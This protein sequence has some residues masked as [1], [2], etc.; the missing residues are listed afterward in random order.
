MDEKTEELRDIF[1]EV[2]E[3][4]SVTETQEELRGS[5][6]TD[7]TEIEERLLSIVGAM[8]ERYDLETPLTRSQLVDVVRS[9]YAG[10]SDDEIARELEES[11]TEPK[12][13]GESDIETAGGESLVE[14]VARARIELHLVSEKDRKRVIDLDAL[15]EIADAGSQKYVDAD[16]SEEETISTAEIAA[17]FDMSESTARRHRRLI[18]VK[19][20]RKLIG[21]RFRQKFE[22][23]LSDQALSDRLTDGIKEDGLED[24]TEGIE[25]DVSF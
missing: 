23:V 2:T 7:E 3:T 17:E 6:A 12:W 14:T 19:T 24:A 9:F 18:E 25:T 4:D 5:I 20:E 8:D 21:D 15:R 10:K 22:H 11:D 13:I 16:S 1:V